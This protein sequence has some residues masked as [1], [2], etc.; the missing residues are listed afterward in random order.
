LP[1]AKNIENK[2]LA[3]PGFKIPPLRKLDFKFDKASDRNY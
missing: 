1:V 2:K 3:S